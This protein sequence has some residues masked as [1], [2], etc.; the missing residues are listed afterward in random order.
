MLFCVSFS[1]DARA[2][3]FKT[4]AAMSQII[5]NMVRHRE[6]TSPPSPTTLTL[7]IQAQPQLFMPCTSISVCMCI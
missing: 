3:R 4:H 6:L 7:I 1:I 2:I 5:T